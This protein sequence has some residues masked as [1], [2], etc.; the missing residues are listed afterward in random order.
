MGDISPETEALQQAIR[1]VFVRELDRIRMD[2]TLTPE[3][4]AALSDASERLNRRLAEMVATGV[5]LAVNEVLGRA[6]A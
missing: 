5:R 2:S 4:L 3:R 6:V 1:A